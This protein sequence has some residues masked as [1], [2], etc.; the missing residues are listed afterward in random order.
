M[1]VTPKVLHQL[2]YIIDPLKM[3]VS[4]S[5][6]QKKFRLIPKILILIWKAPKTF[7]VKIQMR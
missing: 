3:G 5:V 4:M 1:Q 7:L 2:I 6:K